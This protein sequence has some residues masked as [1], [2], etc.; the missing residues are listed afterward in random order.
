V[1]QNNM[2]KITIRQPLLLGGFMGTGKS[3]IGP[4]VAAHANVPFED[5]DATIEARTGKSIA[6]LFH[7]DGET[8][9]RTIEATTLRSLLQNPTPRVIALGGGTLLNTS[10]RNEVLHQA[11]VVNLVAQPETVVSRVRAPGRPLL[12]HAP[13]PLQ[14]VRDLLLARSQAYTDAHAVIRTDHR[15][16][17]EIASAVLSAWQDTSLLVRSST[18]TYAARI[19]RDAP[20][21]VTELTR[22]L[23]PSSVFVVTDEHVHPL[24]TQPVIR[25]LEAAGIYKGVVVLTPGEV[26]KQWPAV[27]QIL[28][29]LLAGGAD[30]NS[31]VVAMGGGVVSDIA[32][33]AAAIFLRG[34]RW[35]AMPTTLLSMVDAAVGGKT[36]VD[37]GLAKNSVGAFHH[38]A[39]VLIDPTY[40]HTESSRAYVSGLAEV[41][42]SGAIADPALIDLL[43]KHPD[44]IL[45]RDI[46]LVET[47]ITRSLHVKTSIVSRDEREAGERMLLNFGHTI[48]H[49]LE[50][51]GNFDRLT[52]G[53]AVA[54]GMI[55]ILRFGQ[56]RGVTS[57]RVVERIE[58]LISQLRLPTDLANEPLEPALM[59][60]GHDKKRVSSHLRLV[61][62]ED[63][64]RARIELVELDEVRA[65]FARNE[66][67]R[68]E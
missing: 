21:A 52:H 37:L 50:A 38:P 68:N 12:D 66:T 6:Q 62:L 20:K 4:L 35:V 5:L 1:K 15:D 10:L 11:R 67:K 43:S 33:F 42:K 3:T 57:A 2:S 40:T 59:L 18:T 16:P 60:L 48:G 64:G 14:R 63:V 61:L 36:A 26:H 54:L 41:I 7:D 45:A 39:G 58:A 23:R 46:E 13:D 55:A 27:Q 53:E 22:V 29:T 8:T 32:G 19:T 51:A 31:I 44:R 65:F 17:T 49:A 56:A 25:A 47:M 24:H 9:F 28:E 34:I 30:R